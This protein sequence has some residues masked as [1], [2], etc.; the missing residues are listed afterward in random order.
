MKKKNGFISMTLVYTFLIL[1]MFLML[2][3]LRTYT[4]KDKFLQAINDQIDNDI[5]VANKG[6]VT[7]INRIIE[8]NMPLSDSSI[9]Y[10]KISN[11]YYG[12][13]GSLYYMDNK[14]YGS[15]TYDL[16]EY[17]DEN[18]DGNTS[19]IYYFRG[20]NEDNHLVF[21]GICFRIIR[22]NEDGS[23]RI[24]YDGKASSSL[25]C[26]TLNDTIENNLVT[27]IN[28]SVIFSDDSVEYVKAIDGVVP[29]ADESSDQ[30]PIIN[31]L[32]EW[33]K[34][35]FIPKNSSDTN[36]TD[37]IS[38]DTIFCNNK[39]SYGSGD[40]YQSREL[41]PVF[42]DKKNKDK[43]KDSNIKNI[44]SFYCPEP[45]DRFS[46]NEGNLVYPVGIPTAQ[47]VVLA[48]GYL[49]V[50]GDEYT[51]GPNGVMDNQGYYMYSKTGYW[52]MS[53]LSPGKVIYVDEN[54]QLSGADVNET[55]GVRPVI[56]LNASIVI[57]SGDGTADNPY[58][59]KTNY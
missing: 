35:S 37:Y 25:K 48:G 38:K 44:I 17:T 2:A 3:I 22:T 58:I 9:N 8:N 11:S 56:S 15:E 20:D 29:D 33:Y 39:V 27:V 10:F 47:D 21:A 18:A 53:P 40:F 31:I 4:E 13:G 5:G 59:V 26:K 30:S 19:R 6:R 36:Y 42:I 45:N 12:N 28:D 49:S 32:N 43:Y 55:H 16:E 50:L 24:M 51:G 52:T 1:F 34:D 41:S 7:I 46:V 54:G 14:T 23:I 57:A